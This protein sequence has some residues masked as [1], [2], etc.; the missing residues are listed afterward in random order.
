MGWLLLVLAIV[1][2]LSGTVAMKLSASFSRL[3]PSILMF[4][5]Y[6]ASFTCLNYTLG[7]M[8]VSTVYAIWSGVG[9]VLI[10][11]VGALIFQEKLSLT[12][13]LWM[14]IIVFGVIGLN[15]SGREG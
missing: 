7:Y 14:G 1:L 8:K 15:L 10:S 2:E 3:G 13:I 6:A 5:F 11:L 4:V 12:S 9:I